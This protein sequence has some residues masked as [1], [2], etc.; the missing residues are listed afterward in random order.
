MNRNTLFRIIWVV[1]ANVVEVST[2]RIKR[3]AVLTEDETIWTKSC[4]DSV[5]FVSDPDFV[6]GFVSFRRPPKKSGT[7]RRLLV[8]LSIHPRGRS[9][10]LR[11]LFHQFELIIV[12]I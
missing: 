9:Q 3:V 4:M 12:F 6:T 2:V 8:F 11:L 7:R 5:D 10:V 1:T